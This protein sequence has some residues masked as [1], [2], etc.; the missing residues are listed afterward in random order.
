MS[1]RE[2]SDTWRRTCKLKTR[3]TTGYVD[4]VLQKRRGRNEKLDMKKIPFALGKLV[5]HWK[6]GMQYEKG[7]Q[8]EG[9]LCKI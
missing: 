2:E 7:T 9:R 8:S 1:A 3:Q 5:G 6:D 4:S